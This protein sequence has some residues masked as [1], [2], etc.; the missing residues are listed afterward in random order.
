MVAPLPCTVT[1]PVIIGRPFPPSTV[2]FALVNV[3]TQRLARVTV[4]P[5]GVLLAVDTAET[6]VETEHCG[7]PVGVVTASAVE[8]GE[9]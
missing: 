2:M 5:P 3:Y 1:L 7:V 6:R 9:V 4:P 8:G